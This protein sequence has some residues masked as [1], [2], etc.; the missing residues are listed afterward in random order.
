M[1]NTL[2]QSRFG[3]PLAAGV[4][5][6]VVMTAYEAL[7]GEI[8]GPL[9]LW[10]SHSITIIFTTILA[11]LVAEGIKGTL[12]KFLEVEQLA[13]ERQQTYAD[14][15][16][17]TT[18]YLNNLLNTFQLMELTREEDGKIPDEVFT[19]VKDEF[20]STARNIRALSMLEN[21]SRESIRKL[22]DN[23]L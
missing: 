18:H 1:L 4:I 2:C 14:A 6:A 21:P 7:K 19:K 16:L 23:S 5:T 10:E 15:M 3:L 9:T 12:Q 22:I 8:F 13:N 17:A 20:E 11:V